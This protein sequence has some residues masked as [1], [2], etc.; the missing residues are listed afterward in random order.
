MCFIA[1]ITIVPAVLVVIHKKETNNR[2]AGSVPSFP[3]RRP[4]QLGSLEGLAAGFGMGPGVSPPMWPPAYIIPAE[5][6]FKVLSL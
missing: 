3:A 4:V 2:G 6:I 1:A 5:Q